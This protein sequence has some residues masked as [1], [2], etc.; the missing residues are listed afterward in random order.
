LQGWQEQ[1]RGGRVTQTWVKTSTEIYQ[2]TQCFQ[3]CYTILLYTPLTGMINRIYLHWNLCCFIWNHKVSTN[4]LSIMGC[5]EGSKLHKYIKITFLC[6]SF[7]YAQ[8]KMY[9][10]HFVCVCVCVFFF[11]FVFATFNTCNCHFPK[12]IFYIS[13]AFRGDGHMIH[14]IKLRTYHRTHGQ[15]RKA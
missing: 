8:K 5:F 12:F 2:N 4:W 11:F 6:L 14:C 13:C 15:K 3:N 10:S 1:W 7:L 9:N